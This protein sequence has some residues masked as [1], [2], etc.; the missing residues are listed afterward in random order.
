VESARPD[1]LIEDPWGAAFVAAVDSP[2]PFPTRWPAEGE[3]PS[4]Q[5]ALHLHGSRYIGVRSRFYDDFL[6]QAVSAGIRQVVLLA[7]GLDT[8]AFRLEW[9]DAEAAVFELD[10][11]NVLAFK[12]EVLDAAG[13][14]AGCR[15]VT[16]GV[17]LR[18]DWPSALRAAGFDA[19]LPTAW[20]AEGL[21]A[22]LPPEA[23]ERLLA[24][25]G[26]LSAPGSRIAADRILAV[27]RLGKDGRALGELS[28]RSGVPMQSLVDTQGRADCAHWLA[29]HGW[30]AQE[31]DAAEV[32]ASYGRDLADPFGRQSAPPWLDTGFVTGLLGGR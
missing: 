31:R 30:T 7:A 9:A 21:L 24:A 8:R 27:D 28:A 22:Y 11:P 32:A 14:Q 17:D 1:R 18:E 2:V 26:E 6:T 25:I 3:V 16:I 5:E 15:R 13:A 20:V 12:D 29:G 4:D 23:E 10:Q 19:A